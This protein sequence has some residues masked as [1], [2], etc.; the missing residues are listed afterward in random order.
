MPPRASSRGGAPCGPGHAANPNG[1]FGSV[2]HRGEAP[3]AISATGAHAARPAAG[4]E[5]PAT[6]ET[7]ART[8]H[9]RH[10]A[11]LLAG[12]AALLTAGCARNPPAEAP[13][14]EEAEEVDVGY[15]TQRAQDITGSVASLSGERLRAN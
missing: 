10:G 13:A 11:L 14:P 2:M 12:L 5:P 6:E 7:M 15:G 3:A 9:R 8:G 1:A 4:G